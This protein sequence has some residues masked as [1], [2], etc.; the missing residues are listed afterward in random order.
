LAHYDALLLFVLGQQFLQFNDRMVHQLAGYDKSLYGSGRQLE[1]QIAEDPF[2]HR[3]QP[4]SA[5]L[6]LDRQFGDA[7]QSVVAEPHFDSVSREGLL[8]LPD[9]AAFGSLQ[10]QEKVIDIELLANHA[11]RQAADEFRLEPEID[12]VARL[13]LGKEE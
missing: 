3:H 2:T 4:A 1:F 7:S 13:R 5:R 10:D 12:E 6:F 9:D 11:H 8:V